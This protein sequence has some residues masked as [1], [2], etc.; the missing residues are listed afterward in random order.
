MSS[1]SNIPRPYYPDY[2]SENAVQHHFNPY[3]DNGG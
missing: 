1:Q 3:A 2:S